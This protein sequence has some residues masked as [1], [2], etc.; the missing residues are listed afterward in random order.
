MTDRLRACVA[1]GSR[2]T[3]HPQSS[4]ISISSPLIPVSAGR[5]YVLTGYVRASRPDS[6]TMVQINASFFRWAPARAV[7]AGTVMPAPST[8]HSATALSLPSEYLL[9]LKLLL[10]LSG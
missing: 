6:T 3:S 7:E 5:S 1:A 8:N 4:L 2:L 9:A 10:Q